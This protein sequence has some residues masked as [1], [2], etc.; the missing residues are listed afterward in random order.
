VEGDRKRIITVEYWQWRYLD[1]KT[2]RM[3]RTVFRLTDKEAAELPE[4]ERIEGTM[5]LR[6]VEVDE[7]D[8]TGP[9]VHELR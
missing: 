6:E 4:A 1:L 7:F 2:G 9:G 3:C 5:L 8:D